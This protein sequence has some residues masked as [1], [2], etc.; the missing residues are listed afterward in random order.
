[1]RAALSRL[2]ALAALLALAACG[3]SDESYP[4][5]LPLSDLTAPPAIPAHAADAAAHPEAVGEALRA[6]RARAAARAGGAQGPVTDAAGLQAR[7]AALRD[8]AG[9]LAAAEPQGG[10]SLTIAP[11]GSDPPEA[12]DPETAAR[13]EALR[14]RARRMLDG[15]PAPSCP[16]GAATCPQP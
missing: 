1:M 15:E 7:A 10:A 13:A 2:F 9:Q 6:R 5:L 16:P 11:A 8:R 12:T 3:G 14:E 4:R